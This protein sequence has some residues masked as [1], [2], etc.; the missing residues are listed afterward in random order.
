MPKTTMKKQ[1]SLVLISVFLFSGIFA[2]TEKK[3]EKKQMK[4]ALLV[5]DV[6][7]KY[8]PWMAD[9][10]KE[11]AIEMINSSIWVFRKFD[12]PVIR[13]YHTDKDWGPEPGSVEFQF[14]DSINIEKS[15]F[16][17]IK[18]YGNAFNKTALDKHLKEKDINTLFLCGLS[19]T[20]CVLATYFGSK[21]NDFEAFLIKDA[22]L[23]P[24]ATD[25]DSVEKMFDALSI[26]T[27][28]FMLE[29]L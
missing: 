19:S 21:D 4:A 13:I 23:G 3:E 28:L 27:I 24:N 1:I 8:L 18:N 16:Q 6:Q 7:N 10:G 9:E 17:I 22:L 20:G 25:T 12:L 26:Q 29:H 15:D 11:S 2:Q 5:I 14:S